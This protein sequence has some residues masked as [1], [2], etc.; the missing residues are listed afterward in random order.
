MSY[1]EKFLTSYSENMRIF[2]R[3]GEVEQA[4]S[5]ET[6]DCRVVPPRNDDLK[7]GKPKE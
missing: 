2:S 5:N 6:L 7:L 1:F 4:L 3:N